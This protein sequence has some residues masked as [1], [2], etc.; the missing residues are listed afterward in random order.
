MGDLNYPQCE[1]KKNLKQKDKNITLKK[2]A[3]KNNIL[4]MTSA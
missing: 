3:I 1:E 4:N 2:R